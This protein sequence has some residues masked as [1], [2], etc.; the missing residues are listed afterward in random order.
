MA[1]KFQAFVSYNMCVYIYTYIK[2]TYSLADIFFFFP[3][4]P[5]KNDRKEEKKVCSFN[6]RDPVHYAKVSCLFYNLFYPL[7]SAILSKF[8]L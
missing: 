3:L 8:S 2:K 4:V 1:Q 5:N 7:Q 6:K